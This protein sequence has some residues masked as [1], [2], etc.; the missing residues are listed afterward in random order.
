[1]VCFTD[2]GSFFVTVGGII[3]CV[4]LVSLVKWHNNIVKWLMFT[5]SVYTSLFVYIFAHA[6]DSQTFSFDM[7][8]VIVSILVLAY[9]M[10]RVMGEQ[11]PF[12]AMRN[13]YISVIAF[14]I[15]LPLVAHNGAILASWIGGQFGVI[16]PFWFGMTTLLLLF[17]LVFFILKRTGVYSELPVVISCL[18]CALLCETF[19]K[20]T[21]LESRVAPESSNNQTESSI[22]GQLVGAILDPIVGTTVAVSVDYS[23]HRL[24]CFSVWSSSIPEQAAYDLTRCPIGFDLWVFDVV[25]GA[26]FVLV[27]LLTYCNRCQR[28][29]VDNKPL[30]PKVSE[31]HT[32]S[33]EVSIRS[34]QERQGMQAVRDEYIHAVQSR[35]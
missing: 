3:A 23:S 31:T 1:M 25:L 24:C 11:V 16:V 5:M 9:I 28:K 7:Y 32:P 12:S 18:V 34:E 20:M 10:S 26:V 4:C 2:V 8:T 19:V 14:L 33:V 21:W 29:K 35:R 30:L 22:P 15:L 6:I 13:G 27:L 17:I